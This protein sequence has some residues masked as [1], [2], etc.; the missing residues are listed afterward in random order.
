M[1]S[2]VTKLDNLQLKE[3]EN[4][5][6]YSIDGG[7]L[8]VKEFAERNLDLLSDLEQALVRKHLHDVPD[9]LFLLASPLVRSQKYSNGKLKMAA[10][11]AGARSAYLPDLGLK[12]KGCRPEDKIFPEW[13]VDKEFN[14]VVGE[15]PFGVLTAEAVMREFLAYCFMQE[16]RILSSSVP[17][18]VFEYRPNRKFMNYGLVSRVTDD[19]RVEGF[20]DCSGYTLHDVVGLKKA[21]R[22][23]GHEAGLKGLNTQDYVEKKTDLLISVNFRGGFRGILNS[24][25]GNDVIRD[26]K[27]YICDFDTFRVSET[28]KKEDRESIRLFVYHS[29]IELIKTSLPFVDYVEFGNDNPEIVHSA[30]ANYYMANSNLYREYNKKFMRVSKTIGWDVKFT[31]ECIDEAFKTKISFELLQEL[32]PNSYTL[33]N[34]KESSFYVPHN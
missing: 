27:L 10:K 31:E 12:I 28:P 2:D 14:V 6:L 13:D 24:N 33:K 17:L 3:G 30:L 7:I 19:T 9:E 20:I 8:L 26:G 16:Y 18:N 22:L 25:I 29:F 1:Q 5:Y 21:G 23:K 15:L 32:I 4:I 11:R 34:F